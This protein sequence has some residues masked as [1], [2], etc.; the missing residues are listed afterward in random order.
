MKS[1]PTMFNWGAI[2]WWEEIFQIDLRH[3][4][5]VA[6]SCGI[7]ATWIGF[8]LNLEEIFCKFAFIKLQYDIS[9]PFFNYMT[10]RVLNHPHMFQPFVH[11]QTGQFF[12]LQDPVMHQHSDSIHAAILHV[13][14]F[15]QVP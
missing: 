5:K 1:Y 8:L 9:I 10:T 14:Q 7:F 4:V 15:H 2:F 3:M 11:F 6:F 12:K 13:P